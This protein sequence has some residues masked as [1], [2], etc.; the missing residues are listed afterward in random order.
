MM[1]DIGGDTLGA[2]VAPST[3]VPGE[4][5][6]VRTSVCFIHGSA[7]NVSPSG[8]RVTDTSWDA[9]APTSIGYSNVTA[10]SSPPV[11]APWPAREP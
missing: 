8:K 6:A 9:S 10:A 3:V 1:R 7:A 2:T 4:N 11:G 5:V